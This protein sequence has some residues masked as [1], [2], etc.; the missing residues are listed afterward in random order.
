MRT[1]YI[2]ILSIISNN[3]YKSAEQ[4]MQIASEM[5]N[6]NTFCIA[7]NDRLTTTVLKTFNR[8]VTMLEE[9]LIV[10]NEQSYCHLVI[11]KSVGPL[12]I[13]DNKPIR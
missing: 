8:E 1:D 6:A 5:I 10:D 4:V 11:E 9:G 3:L 7:I 13:Q 12:V 2:D